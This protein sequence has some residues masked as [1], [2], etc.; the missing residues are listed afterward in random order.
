MNVLELPLELGLFPNGVEY[1]ERDQDAAIEQVAS[2]RQIFD[3]VQDDRTL[4]VEESLLVVRVQHAS[5]VSTAGR[6]PATR[7]AEPILH[8]GKVVEAQ[9]PRS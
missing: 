7:V 2:R 1:R 4:S 6:E 3:P 8:L 5:A 9:G